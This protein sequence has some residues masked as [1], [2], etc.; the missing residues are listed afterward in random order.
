MSESDL[1][2]RSS[3]LSS[4]IALTAHWRSYWRGLSGGP[5]RWNAETWLLK[6]KSLPRRSFVPAEL[7]VDDAVEPSRIR[8][9]KVQREQT[10][11]VS[12]RW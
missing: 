12:A 7:P 10:A 1:G 11:F 9:M 6:C 4:G 5:L 8:G 2:R 3:E